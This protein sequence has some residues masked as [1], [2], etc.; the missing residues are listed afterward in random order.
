[1]IA[2]SLRKAARCGRIC[3]Q[4]VM[5]RDQPQDRLLGARLPSTQREGSPTPGAAA[6]AQASRRRHGRRGLGTGVRTRVRPRQR[7]VTPSPGPSTSTESTDGCC[8]QR[9]GLGSRV[10]VRVRRGPFGETRPLPADQFAGLSPQRHLEMRV[11]GVRPRSNPAHAHLGGSG[12][13]LLP[14]SRGSWPGSFAWPARRRCAPSRRRS[15][16]SWARSSRCTSTP[17][18]WP[19][20]ARRRC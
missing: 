20:R 19:D 1:M 8:T 10:G 11:S 18:V 4:T 2:N 15:H 5:L 17:P 6:S 14:V 3:T 7:L 13:R 12:Y 16:G 9:S